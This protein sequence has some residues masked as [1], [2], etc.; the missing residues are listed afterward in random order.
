MPTSP[1]KDRPSAA[2]RRQAEVEDL[3][4]GLRPVTTRAVL[5]AALLGAARP[6]LPAAHL[7]AVGSLFGISAGATR[8]CLWRMVADGELTTDD[9]TYALA[10]RLLERRRQVDT[11]AR[12]AP[13]PAGWDGTWEIAVVAAD[14]RGAMDRIGLR[15]AA[16]ALHLA[17]IREGTWARPDNLDP[18]RLPHARAVLDQQC[19]RFSDASSDITTDAVG[20]FFELDT[21]ATHAHRFLRAM[22]DE[23]G[24][25]PYDHDDIGPTLSHQFTLSIAVVSHLERDPL[26]P[27]ELLPPNW[28]ADDLRT[29]YRAFDT[30]FQHT[31]NTAL[32]GP[33]RAAHEHGNL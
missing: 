7:V 31:M 9:A 26:L 23:I 25:A 33:G 15:K 8:T 28:P 2:A 27:A 5:A 32:A 18:G 20:S 21:W 22:R 10:G 11:V 24:A 13:T 12:A 6:E 16:A 14:R 29:S 3:L 1:A 30:H 4:A 17:E 19:I